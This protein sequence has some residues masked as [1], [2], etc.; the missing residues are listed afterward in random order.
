KVGF[1][2]SIQLKFIIIYI[3]LLLVAIQVIGSYFARQ[4][5]TELLDNFKVSVNDR[6]ELLSYNLE[7]AFNKERTE[8]DDEPTLEEEV[9]GIV[10]DVDT[11]TITTLQ[12]VNSQSR[13]IG[14]NDYLNSDIIGKKTTDDIIQ[15]ALKF[16]SSLDDTVLNAETRN[17]FFIKAEPIYD[18]DGNVT[19]AIY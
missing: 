14:S 2:R 15:K 17:R 5:E 16:G 11:E 9:Q 10:T 12:V 7:Q 8:E 4:L 18:Q 19:G 1:F 3:L 13:V 6:V